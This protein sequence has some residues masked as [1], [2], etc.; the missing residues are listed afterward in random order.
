MGQIFLTGVT[1]DAFVKAVDIVGE[2]EED[3]G[4]FEKFID[5]VGLGKKVMNFDFADRARIFGFIFF[6]LLLGILFVNFD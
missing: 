3:L 1:Q 2:G 4:L 6:L 5:I